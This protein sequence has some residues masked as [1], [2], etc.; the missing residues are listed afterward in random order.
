MRAK[1][2]GGVSSGGAAFGRMSV[3]EALAHPWMASFFTGTE[4]VCPGKLTIPVDDDIKYS[5]S[6]YRERLYHMLQANR[7][8]KSA[9]M[10]RRAAPAS[11]ATPA[12]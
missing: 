3:Q 4:L 10:V 2:T 7:K 12:P 1:R 9:R 8:D 6:D 11:A 5:L